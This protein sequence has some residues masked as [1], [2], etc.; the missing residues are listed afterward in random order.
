M[1]SSH[2]SDWLPLT[3]GTFISVDASPPSLYITCF[4][5]VFFRRSGEPLYQW[6]QN[7]YALVPVGKRRYAG[8]KYLHLN[9]R[10]SF[11]TAKRSSIESRWGNLQVR[12]KPVI[13][14]CTLVPPAD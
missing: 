12:T 1:A 9:F 13:R 14:N 7:K 3:F 8:D 6:I 11:F 4:H 10:L 5:L 2:G